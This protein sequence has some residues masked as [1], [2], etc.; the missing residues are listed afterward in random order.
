MTAALDHD[1]AQDSDQQINEPLMK[2]IYRETKHIKYQATKYRKKHKNPEKS[3]Q[4]SRSFTLASDL[5]Q[6]LVPAENTNKK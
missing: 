3:Q 2:N 6:Q 4:E 1:A 5:M